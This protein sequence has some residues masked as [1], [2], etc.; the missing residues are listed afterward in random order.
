[1]IVLIPISKFRVVYEVAEGQPYSHLERLVLKAVSSGVHSMDELRKTFEIHPRLLIESLVTLT[2]AGWI[3]LGRSSNE[4]FVPTPEG[5]RAI[6]EGQVPDSIV[7]S[8]RTA[9]VLLERITGTI[10]PDGE[11]RY[12]PKK[13]LEKEGLWDSCVRLRSEIFDNLLDE[14]QVQ[15]FLPRDQ[16]QR[17]HWV[18]P[19]DMVT[20]GGHYIPASVDE[21]GSVVHNLPQRSGSYLREIVL[22]RARGEAA[23][24]HSDAESDIDWEE[25]FGRRKPSQPLS[26]KSWDISVSWG[27]E[28]WLIRN[29]RAHEEFLLEA[30]A[31]SCHSFLVLSGS[32]SLMALERLRPN[33]LDAL[34]RGVDVDILWGSSS[35][36]GLLDWMKQ[37]AYEAKQK[38]FLGRVRFNR[39]AS[40]CN[41]NVIIWDDSSGVV[42]AGISSG[43]WLGSSSL[44]V[45]RIGIGVSHPEV[46]AGLCWYIAGLWASVR[47]EV[48]SSVPDRWRRVASSLEANFRAQDFD[49]SGDPVLLRLLRDNE[50]LNT[51]DVIGG[52]K[53]LSIVTGQAKSES[54]LEVPKYLH[55]GAV[56]DIKLLPG[57]V[58]G[59][60]VTGDTLCITSANL[61]LQPRVTEE[62]EREIGIVVKGQKPTR[63]V[64]EAL[65]TALLREGKEEQR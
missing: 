34:A 41:G 20:K 58:G 3:A 35:E 33:F 6:A 14:G 2:H 63:E 9:F 18:G 55:L 37:L 53:P 48:L 42:R 25:L 64:A 29:D 36:R 19:I 30:L 1:M 32:M 61:A 4:Q 39:E 46:V 7:I 40:G 12:V 54:P 23:K 62:R 11:V 10:M 24:L 50:H 5:R 43:G 22:D 65:E 8:R 59:A 47:S 21:S 49:A 17:L 56:A 52:S 15:Q 60:I 44:D 13:L 28:A 16:G 38:E 31:S 45:V 51:V 26:E 27:Q 57:M